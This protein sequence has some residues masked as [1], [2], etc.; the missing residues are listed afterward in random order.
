MHESDPLD[1]LAQVSG[2]AAEYRD[3]WHRTH[4]ASAATRRALLRAMGF[5]VDSDRDLR[6]AL[7][8]HDARSWHRPLPPVLV[9]REPFDVPQVELSV[10][11][12]RAEKNWTALLETEDGARD[13]QT[14]RPAGLPVLDRRDV[15]GR[16]MLRC[17]L[18]LPRAPALGYHDLRLTEP[19]G[20]VS[21][22]MRW[23]VAPRH[24]HIPR[25]LEGQRRVWGPNVQLYALR[26]RRNWGIGDFT[27]LTRLVEGCAEA[28]AGIVGLGPLHALFPDRPEQASPYSPSSRAFVN[29][30]YLDVEAVPEFADSDETRRIVSGPEFQ[31]VL[32][33]LREIDL[34]DYGAVA[35]TK[36]R[37]L[38]LLYAEFRE[39]HL[40]ADTGRGRA[41][42]RFQA[43]G[44]NVLAAHG[45]FEALQ[46]H[47]ASDAAGPRGWQEWPAPYR[48]PAST[49]VAALGRDKLERV[50]F[51]QYLQWLCEAQLETAGRRSLE[52]ELGVGLFSDLAVSVD[53]AGFETWRHREI[54]ATGASIGA[55]P[56]EFSQ[57]GQDWGLPPW[58]P[59]RLRASAYR[60]FI[61]CLRANMRHAGALRVDH[62]MGLMRAFW[63]PTGR[64]ACE[65]AYVAYPFEDLLGVLALESRR[66]RCLVVGEDLGTV[67]DRVR[68][69]MRESGILSYRV[70]FFMKQED[71]RICSPDEVP[72]RALV[73][74]TT[75]DLPTLAGYWTGR[76]IERRIE[77][78]LFPAETSAD[79]VLRQRAVDRERLL[80]ALREEGLL[81]AGFVAGPR[82][83]PQLALAIHRY[84]ARS[85]AKILAFQL[86]DVLGQIEQTNLPG[87][88]GDHPNWCRKLDLELESLE[89]DSRIA[90]LAS[91]LVA[92]RGRGA[93][94]AGS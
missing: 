51:F 75:H 40:E 49:E 14:F 53:R 38:E 21:L 29:Y 62:V 44:G 57:R 65:G 12:A 34:V 92:E 60:P 93:G 7:A 59:E 54:Y 80:A 33:E 4:R 31:A 87:T 52:S 27:D 70:L 74:A 48:N 73:A 58:I 16:A 69:A 37:V 11:V 55:P 26:S 32:S 30:L 79:E 83:T 66:N 81:P 22:P 82:M 13:E 88:T 15:D 41:F 3:V 89:G 47:F 46:E 36:R 5:T 72:E 84:L 25:G 19:N 2:I 77:L 76:D 9:S 67:P 28:G 78:G 85:P 42:R 1:A 35:R 23:I 61:E 50:E 64:P 20:V 17:R 68:R 90:E 18:E 24:C 10:P 43:D 91:T 45:V 39:R 94:N 56:D 8:A 63:V 86:E 6:A 71:G